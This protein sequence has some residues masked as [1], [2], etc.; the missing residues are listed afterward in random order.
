MNEKLLHRRQKGTLFFASFL[1]LVACPSF[2]QNGLTVF[3]N[4]HVGPATELHVKSYTINLPGVATTQRETPQGVVSLSSDAAVGSVSPTGFINGFV[5]SYTT[6]AV[7]F[8]VGSTAYAPITITP[9]T[10]TALD[11]A[12]NNGTFNPTVFDPLVLEELSATGYWDVLGANSGTVTL[13]WQQVTNLGDITTDLTKLTIAGWNG[14][15]WV[16][17]AGITG[18]GATL[19]EGTITSNAVVDFTAY[20]AF[21]FA[22]VYEA[23]VAGVTGFDASKT[24]MLL[25]NGQFELSSIQQV[26]QVEVYD[27]NGRLVQLYSVNATDYQNNFNH[28]T[29]IYIAKALLDNGKTVTRKLLNR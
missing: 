5:R 29:G 9:T 20:S 12:Y 4:T 11:V 14:T 10:A 8:P 28:A 18:S 23:P 22:K 17:L 3:G 7:V 1:G 13:A 21:T 6:G 24:F 19:T 16:A 27:V 25:Q 15:A 26:K 2:A